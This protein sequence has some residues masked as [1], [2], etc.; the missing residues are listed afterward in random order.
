MVH[1]LAVLTSP[2]PA[3]TF[4]DHFRPCILARV[5]GDFHTSAPSISPP[6][7]PFTPPAMP[8]PTACRIVTISPDFRFATDCKTAKNSSAAVAYEEFAKAAPPG[9]RGLQIRRPVRL[10]WQAIRAEKN[11]SPRLRDLALVGVSTAALLSANPGQGGIK[12]A[13][14]KPCPPRTPG[15]D[16]AR[17]RR[18]SRSP[19]PPTA[20]AG[21]CPDGSRRARC[22]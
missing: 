14:L 5:V 21:G 16:G 17:C 7:V 22:V 13:A 4:F 18:R 3:L 19:S 9:R 6:S 15:D 10:D 11:P 8:L 12:N 1:H 20:G 2:A